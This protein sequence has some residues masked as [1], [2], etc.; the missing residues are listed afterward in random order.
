M[1]LQ[2]RTKRWLRVLR[3]A[4]AMLKAGIEQFDT[5]AAHAH[6]P[7]VRQISKRDKT[8]MVVLPLDQMSL[9]LASQSLA[10]GSWLAETLSDVISS[11]KGVVYD[12]GW[13]DSVLRLLAAVEAAIPALQTRA[14]EPDASLDEIVDELGRALLISLI[15][16]LT[17]HNTIV[18]KEGE[19]TAQHQRFIQGGN[20]SDPGHYL[21]VKTL[22]FV[23]KPGP[24][25]VHMQDLVS[26]LSGGMTVIAFGAD[27]ATVDNYPEAISVNYAQWFAYIFALWEE[28]FRGRIAKYFDVPD[29]RIRRSDVL[30]DYF[31]DIRRIRNDFVHNKGICKESAET[32]V[33]Q[34][35]LVAGEP[36]EITPEQMFSLIDLFPRDELRTPPTP[37]QPGDRKPAPGRLD[38]HIF[39]D[40][41]ERASELGLPDN[42]LA[43]AA[44]TAWLN[45]TA[46]EGGSG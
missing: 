16:T 18:T 28:Q 19:W 2:S 34:W 14:T 31:G 7:G 25:R 4:Q 17:A 1:Y 22:S 8:V 43:D 29:A 13:R 40:V 38:A 23:D 37:R 44:F 36:I 45:A 39:E 9:T 42:E 24:G 46:G 3:G 26:A 15:V 5:F 10:P 27:R 11:L 6:E 33:L 30:V 20:C 35:A 32:V 41:R 12:D 21:N